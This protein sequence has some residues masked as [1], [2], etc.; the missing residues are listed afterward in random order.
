MN[1]EKKLDEIIKRLNKIEEKISNI[2]SKIDAVSE[3]L[4][5]L[6]VKFE[7]RS[8]EDDTILDTKADIDLIKQLN[9]KIILFEEF[10]QNY[11]KTLLMKESY[12]KRLN[13][14]IHRAVNSLCK[15]LSEIFTGSGIVWTTVLKRLRT[16][17]QRYH[18]IKA[19]CK[20][21]DYDN[22]RALYLI[23]CFVACSNF[24]NTKAQL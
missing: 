11:E 17:V 15:K 13:I 16:P 12:E 22:N 4:N 5:L 10:Q 8:I 19:I 2:D 9:Q 7:N 23:N 1:L 3:R 20:Q 21:F 14:L 24:W 6:E 18:K